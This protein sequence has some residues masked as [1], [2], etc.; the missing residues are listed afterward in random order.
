M[1]PAAAADSQASIC[2]ACGP[3]DFRIE[4]RD[5]GGN[6]SIYAELAMQL[7][8]DW[9]AGALLPQDPALRRHGGRLDGRR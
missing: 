4:K 5:G 3:C 2:P 9:W 8:R 6:F 7:T 1:S